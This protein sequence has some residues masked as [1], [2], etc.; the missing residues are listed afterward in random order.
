MREGARPAHARERELKMAERV[1]GEYGAEQI[2]VLDGLEH[3]RK[4]PGMY[5]S[6]TDAKG[7]HH[8]VHEVVDNSIDEALAGY[9]THIEVTLNPDGSCTV[10]DNGR[11]IPTDIHPKEGISTLEVVFT[12]VNAGGKFG[13]DSGYK[14]SSGL[15][16]V[17]VKAV[18]A[19]SEWLEAEVY[20]NGHIYKQ[21]YNRGVPQRSVAIVGDTD[22]TGTKVTFMPDD[23][24]FET[25]VFNYDALKGRLRELAYLN[26]GLRITLE[27]KR[28]G[29]EKKDSFCYEGGIRSFV[30][31]LNKN[32]DEVLFPQ[33]VYFEETDGDTVCEVAIQYNESY[34]EVIYSYANNVNTIDGGTHVEG[35]KMALTKVIN[36]AGRKL[37]ILKESDKLTGEDVREGITAVVSVKLIN[38]QF[39]SQTK[40]KLNNSS[41][42]A[43]VN[44]CVTEHMGT[45]L[46]ENPAVARVLV[47]RCITAQKARDA[48]RNARELT[49]RKGV[50]ESSTL[51]GKLADCSDRRPEL[52]EIYIVEG[53]S[54]GG[55]AKQGRDRRFQAILPLR[56][57]IL[58]VEKVRLNRVLEN[59]EIK[60]MI[61]AFGCGILDDFDESKLRYDRIISMTDADVDGAH[62][63]ILLFTF[64]FRFMRP[65]IEHGHVYSAKPPLYKATSKG[66]E[67]YL[68]TEEEKIAYDAAAT[69]K[70]E[71]QRYKGLGEMSKE[72]LWDTT[73]NPA[74]RTL[75]RVTMEDA[76]EADQMF[77]ML[78][79]ENPELRRKFIEENASLVTDLDI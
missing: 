5:I 56:G 25:T 4:R 77:A 40:D 76:A 32:R 12:K 16:G 54:A 14:V 46:E 49:R 78:M 31:E 33:P 69:S 6:S 53:D 79:G 73:M 20:Q 1:E 24:I 7:L 60:S 26:K 75:V 44:K 70:V 58:N 57:K 8:L 19:L 34:N 68:Y 22:I 42:R 13:G 18:N 71:Y 17:G 11:G 37:N 64:L 27:D 62:I 72:Q 30:E 10:Q 61:T 50:L 52:C 63:R 35:L 23:E 9:C 66:R 39:E 55:T 59:E 48:A 28:P 29:E 15:H 74:T 45:F 38:A 65:L 51:P 3:I 21:V 47:L 2:Q 36:D 43:F 67:D 41:I